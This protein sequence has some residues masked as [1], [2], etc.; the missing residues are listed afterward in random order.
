MTSSF[1]T[2]ATLGYIR[3]PRMNLQPPASKRGILVSPLE[4][5]SLVP[6]FPHSHEELSLSLGQAAE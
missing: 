4:F 5:H 1:D 2:T 3:P 6:G